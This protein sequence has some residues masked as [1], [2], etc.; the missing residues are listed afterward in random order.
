MFPFY[1]LYTQY[2]QNIHNN[3][4]TVLATRQGKDWGETQIQISCKNIIYI[5]M[6]PFSQCIHTICTQ[7]A[8]NTQNI[9][10]TYTQ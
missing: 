8:Q 10:T 6:F 2:T 1:T 4:Q 7:Y 5:Y 3:K 9:H